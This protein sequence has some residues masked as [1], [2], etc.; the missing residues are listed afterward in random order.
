VYGGI[1]SSE[2]MGYIKAVDHF[3]MIAIQTFRVNDHEGANNKF[4]LYQFK[5]YNNG[6]SRVLQTPL[7]A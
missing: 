6:L 2:T 3:M 5:D 7:S 1:F 4:I